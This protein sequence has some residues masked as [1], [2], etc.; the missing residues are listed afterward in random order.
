VAG[1]GG[2]GAVVVLAGAG[3]ELAGAGVVLGVA[4][5]ADFGAAGADAAV[6]VEVEAVEGD[7]TLG[8]TAV[9][10]SAAAAV[11]PADA[12]TVMLGAV[13]ATELVDGA[14]V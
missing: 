8:E 12:D 11:F 9:L 5:E 4:T 6:D 10:T 2:L 13:P 3:A 7:D 1:A 14:A